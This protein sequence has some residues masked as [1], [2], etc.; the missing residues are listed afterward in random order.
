MRLPA[1]RTGAAFLIAPLLAAKLAAACTLP[2]TQ[3]ASAG[4]WMGEDVRAAGPQALRPP[5]SALLSFSQ[6]DFLITTLTRANQ[7]A[8]VLARATG[9]SWTAVA[10]LERGTPAGAATRLSWVPSAVPGA[11]GAKLNLQT[12]ERLYQMMLGRQPTELFRLPSATASGGAGSVR[13]DQALRSIAEWRNCYAQQWG[14]AATGS[15]LARWESATLQSVAQPKASALSVAARA[16]DAQ[17][18]PI[19]DAHIAFARGEH[20]ACTAKTDARGMAACVLWDGHGHGPQAHGHDEDATIATFSGVVRP[21]VIL[22]P[23]AVLLRP[24]RR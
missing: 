23:T 24:A 5:P 21:E 16:L 9:K 17:R 6:D 4:S 3:P 14:G 7:S 1:V 13:Y 2:F 8:Q 12:L 18:K 20:L 11:G 22:L 10:Q 19:A 15:P